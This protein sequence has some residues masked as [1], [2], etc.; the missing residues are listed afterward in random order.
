MRLRVC[1]YWLGVL[2]MVPLTAHA[3]LFSLS[4]QDEIAIGR[5]AAAKVEQQ[6]RMYPDADVQRYVSHLGMQLARLSTRPNLP[7]RL[8]VIDDPHINA[9][10][11]PGGFIYVNSKV[12]Q[13]A[14][15]EAQLAAVL[16]HE[17]GHIEGRHHKKKIEQAMRYQLGLGVLGTVLGNGGG[18][19]AA[20]IA[21]KLLAEGELTRYSREAENDA[22]RRGVALLYRAGF[23]PM[24]MSRFLEKLV[25]LQ[26]RNPDMLSSFFADHP[27]PKQRVAL[28]KALARGYKPRVWRTDSAAFLR[29]SRRLGGAAATLH[30]MEGQEVPG[31]RGARIPPRH[32]RMPGAV[33]HPLRP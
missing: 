5:E 22:D 16:A 25:A 7:W 11:L 13:V 1:V 19:N 8:R 9:F 31:S 14:G 15:S 26:P 27:A 3:G 30:D 29:I 10:A 6:Y 20:M 4:E 21:G 12:L 28:T 17:I 18:A 2:A 32:R 33:L 24:A 23:D